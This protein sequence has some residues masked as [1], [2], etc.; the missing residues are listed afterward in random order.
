LMALCRSKSWN[1]AF[2][3][4]LGRD[5]QRRGIRVTGWRWKWQRRRPNDDVRSPSTIAKQISE[6][7]FIPILKNQ[8][9]CKH[10][11]NSRSVC[12]CYF[13]CV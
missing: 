10:D 6:S 4:L 3:H 2:V 11:R 1:S 12:M 8:Y 5:G 7:L 9:T 13:S